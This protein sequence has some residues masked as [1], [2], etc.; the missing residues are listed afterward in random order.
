MVLAIEALFAPHGVSSHLIRPFKKWLVLNLLEN[1]MYRFSEHCINCLGV[2]RPGLSSLISLRLVIVES[3]RPEIPPFL[4]DN[5]RFTFPLL[6]VFLD[7]LVFINPVHEL[8]HT[9]NMLAS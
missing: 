9:G 6:L 7:L 1:L 2:G 5:L 3:V 4:R 8:T